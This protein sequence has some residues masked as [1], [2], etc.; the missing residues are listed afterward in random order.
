MV[1]SP[2]KAE[3]QEN[4]SVC[5]RGV[6]TASLRPPELVNVKIAMKGNSMES[7][8]LFV[9]FEDGTCI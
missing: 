7:R 5:M 9:G 1:S 4:T 2:I 3:W 8:G 6:Q